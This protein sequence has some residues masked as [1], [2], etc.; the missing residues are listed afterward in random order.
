MN[1]II[2]FSGGKDSLGL[3]CDSLQ[4]GQEVLLLHFCYDHS[5]NESELAAVKKLYSIF[6]LEY[7]DLIKIK[8]I[9]LPFL[10][11][12][13]MNKSFARIVYNRNAIFLNIAINL[14]CSLGYK[15]I[16][17]GAVKN[18]NEDYFDCRK[19]FVIAMNQISSLWGIKILA[20]YVT[21]TKQELKPI[22]KK[23][24]KFSSS[25]YDPIFINLNWVACKKC[26]S[27][28]EGKE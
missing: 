2:L 17:F 9:D 6:K 8:I 5:A 28:L 7:N 24:S 23:Y 26:N 21:M 11:T 19:E 22:L 16:E 13:D 18:D 15:I 1:K 4:Q 3:V 27:C 14:A 20:P 25:C 10:N 12:K